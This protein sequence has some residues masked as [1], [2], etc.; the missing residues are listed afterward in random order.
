MSPLVATHA[1]VATVALILGA[2]LLLRRRKGDRLHR[3]VGAAW[4]TAM[5]FTVLSS[6]WIPALDP[7]QFSWIHGLSAFTFCTLTAAVLAARS[8]RARL[9][10]SFAVGSYLGL[11]GAFVGAVAVPRREIPQLLVHSPATFAAAALACGAVA[12]LVVRL[13]GHRSRRQLVA[14]PR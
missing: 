14:A 1:A 4:A 6:F 10:R 5:Y 7:A 9:H 11:V 2:Q 3:R 8:G 12:L 13:A